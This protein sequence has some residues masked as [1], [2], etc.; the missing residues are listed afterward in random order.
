MLAALS[1]TIATKSS[2]GNLGADEDAPDTSKG[3]AESLALSR[4]VAEDLGLVILL[5]PVATGVSIR[6]CFT[7]DGVCFMS[8][9]CVFHGRERGTR[10]VFPPSII[11]NVCLL[12]C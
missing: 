5:A 3:S 7:Q 10:H 6:T 1:P 8:V 4:S 9:H 2:H 12:V 11:G